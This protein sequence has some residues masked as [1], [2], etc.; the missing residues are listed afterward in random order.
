MKTSGG[1]FTSIDHSNF[2]DNTGQVLHAN[3]TNVSISHSE[4]VGNNGDCNTMHIFHGMIPSIN[5]SK[6]INNTGLHILDA[7]N[8][9]M[10]SITHSEFVDDTATNSFLFHGEVAIP[11]SLVYFDGVMVVVK[12]SEFINN[13]A[14]ISVVYLKYQ[15]AAENLTNNVFIENNAGYEV[16]IGS[17]CRPDFSLSL[18]SFRCIQCTGYWHRNLI[19]IMVA[20]FIAELV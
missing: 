12:S 9:S 19:G 18:G 4:F 2:I 17:A 13:R 1:I 11:G 15:T 10:V 7:T 20:T 6:F 3:H 5:H 16:F 14:G 8:S